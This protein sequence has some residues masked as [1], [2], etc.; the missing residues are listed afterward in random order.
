MRAETRTASTNGAYRD[1]VTD[2]L[3]ET[4]PNKPEVVTNL[5]PLGKQSD[6]V[7]QTLTRLVGPEAVY[8]RGDDIVQVGED[9]DAGTARLVSLTL[10]SLPGVADRAANFIKLR[11]DRKGQAEPVPVFPP[12]AVM[13]DILARRAP[14]LRRLRQLLS[15]PAIL[16]DGRLLAA[17]GYDAETGLFLAYPRGFE[18]P[19]IPERPSQ[20]EA[21]AALERLRDVYVDFPF[22]SQADAD[23]A[24]GELIAVETRSSRPLVGPGCATPMFLHDGTLPG[25]GKG[26]LANLNAVVATGQGAA[27][28]TA[29]GADPAEWR[30]RLTSHIQAAAPLVLLDN[31]EEPLSDASLCAALTSEGYWTDRLLGSNRV[32]RLPI[33]SLFVLTGNNIILKGDLQR[34]VVPVRII[35]DCERPDLKPAAAF[36]HPRLLD[37][38]LEHRGELLAALTMC[39]AWFVAGCPLPETPVLGSFELFCQQVGGI[40]VYAGA[41]QWLRNQESYRDAQDD[42]RAAWR[43][44][45]TE[46]YSLLSEKRVTVAELRPLLQGEGDSEGVA[47]AKAF[48]EALPPEL[49]PTTDREQASFPQRLGVALKR[50][51]DQPFG[52]LVLR[53]AAGTG[54]GGGRR[55]YVTPAPLARTRTYDSAVSVTPV[56][57]VTSQSQNEPRPSEH[58]SPPA[59]EVSPPAEQVSPPPDQQSEFKTAPDGDTGDRGDTQEPVLP[60]THT[61]PSAAYAGALAG[62]AAVEVTRPE[63]PTPEHRLIQSGAELAEAL[64]ALLAA[65]RVAVDI[66]TT[67]LDPLRDRL[68]LV[69]LAAAGQPVLLVDARAVDPRLLAPVFDGSRLLLLH[70]G[71]FDLGFLLRAGVDLRCKR[72][73]DTMLNDQLLEACS[74]TFPKGGRFSLASVVERRLGV[75]L[76]KDLQTSDW[77]GGLASAQ[78]EYAARDAA[79]LLDLASDQEAELRAAGLLW[80]AALEGRATPAVAWLEVGGCPIDAEAWRRRADEAVLA[81]HRA[82]QRLGDLADHRD[83]FGTS[84]VDWS[85]PQQ[86]LKLLRAR[87]HSLETTEAEALAHIADADP[88][89]PE[90]LAYREAARRASTYG[91]DFIRQYLHDADGR[92]HPRY[93]LIGASTGRMSCDHPNVQQI[94]RAPEY[95]RTI[96]APAGRALVKADY[97]QI[98]LRLSA[99]LARDEALIGVFEHGEDPHALTA[100]LV[101]GIPAE[102]VSKE[103]RQQAKALNFGLQYGMGAP[104]LREHALNNYGV[105]FTEQQAATFRQRLFETYRGLR[106]WHL[107]VGRTRGP[108]ETRTP[109]GRRRLDVSRFTE[110]L[111][112]PIQGAGADGIKGALALAWERRAEVPSAQLVLCVHDELVAECDVADAGACAAWLQ[113]CMTDAMQ[114]WLTSVPVEVETTAGRDWAG[115]AL[116]ET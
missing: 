84:T 87:G 46:W 28:Q 90:L 19:R 40:L 43:A 53:L 3:N 113:R 13:R 2:L 54:H 49:V 73:V 60:A 78:L 103:A 92:L 112:S 56:T 31:L 101:L 18:M 58:V 50:H 25:S 77:S 33:V 68:C 93:R 1:A 29:E 7:V 61:P 95:R 65:D 17:Q 38:A 99:D 37:Y 106:R 62:D 104:R 89:V 110:K 57:S 71:T 76:P 102:Q 26:K 16:R 20:D 30:K 105:I 52:S 41:D 39:R 116:E 44:F 70:N 51:Q 21:H 8:G 69:Q 14:E 42:D 45:I 75:A 35:A 23:N 11:M 86:I 48:R 12:P 66:E 115:T 55:W 72:I 5:W 15:A 36:R 79:V 114:P 4:G 32:T 80:V 109:A 47:D 74:A 98:E 94:P 10:D 111:S 107:E 64:L 108:I 24:I 9:P 27:L 22:E 91:L 34:R 59:E 88:L 96:A 97:G 83:M 100:A 82:L 85:S 67:G 81:K 63:S 6:V